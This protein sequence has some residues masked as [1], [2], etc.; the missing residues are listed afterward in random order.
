MF[1]CASRDKIKA[2]LIKF[3][4]KSHCVINNLFGIFF[5]LGLACLVEGDTDA[6]DAV[7]LGTALEAREDGKVDLFGKLS[8]RE[9]QGSNWATESFSGSHGDYVSVGE[10]G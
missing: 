2:K 8:L 4:G 1:V 5:E 3:G 10:G 6:G 7:V 9:N